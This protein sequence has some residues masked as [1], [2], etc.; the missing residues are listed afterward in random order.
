MEKSID[1]PEENNPISPDQNEEY[2]TDYQI[3]HEE[4]YED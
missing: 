3:D 2:D 4:S 1:P